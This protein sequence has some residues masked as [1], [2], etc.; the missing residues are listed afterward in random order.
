MFLG[1]WFYIQLNEGKPVPMPKI[2]KT[3]DIPVMKRLKRLIERMI[4]AQGKDRCKIQ[5]VLN[6]IE[7][8]RGNVV[9][10]AWFSLL[11]LVYYF[12]RLYLSTYIGSAKRS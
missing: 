3:T 12:S 11:Y 8:I 9:S 5:E 4:C 7:E 6:K 10:F 2:E 1:K